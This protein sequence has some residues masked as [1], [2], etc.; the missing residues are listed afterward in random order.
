MYRHLAYWPSYLALVRTM[1][2]PLQREGRLDRADAF[3]PRARPRPW[4]GAG[5]ATETFDAAGYAQGRAR[6]LPAVRRTSDR[7]HDRALCPDPPR[8]A[9]MHFVLRVFLTRTVPLARTL[10]HL[11]LAVAQAIDAADD[12]QLSLADRRAE[13]RRRRLQLRD[14]VDH[15]SPGRVGELVAGLVRNRLH[16]RRQRGDQRRQMAGQGGV[17]LQRLDGCID[18]A[19]AFVAEH[20]NE[21]RV[22]HRDRIFQARDRVVIGEIAG[23]AADE[24]VAAAAVEGVFG[25]DAGIR[26]AQDAGIGILPAGQCL[27]LVLEIVPARDAFDIAARCPSSAAPAPHPAKSRSAALAAALYPWQRRA[28]RRPGRR[29]CRPRRSGS[30]GA[31]VASIERLH[32]Y[33]RGGT[34]QFSRKKKNEPNG[35]FRFM[36]PTAA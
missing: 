18:R 1:L 11:D 24:Q 8:D 29:R 28:A 16:R 32:W 30:G 25:R 26:A 31:S 15:V 20:Q 10:N 14:G 19:A 21:R 3:D 36:S 12:F 9:G 34:S 2:A 4:R 13:D 22:E 33:R 7:A 17:V 6:V 5:V 23:D 27:A 35:T